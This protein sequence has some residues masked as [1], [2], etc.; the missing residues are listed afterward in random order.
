V[1]GS[2]MSHHSINVCVFV[3]SFITRDNLLTFLSDLFHCVVIQYEIRADDSNVM[4]IF[5]VPTHY[6]LS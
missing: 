4:M 3:P 5:T 1:A 2:P 6:C